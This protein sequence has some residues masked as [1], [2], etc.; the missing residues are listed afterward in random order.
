MTG[1]AYSPP[2][3]IESEDQL[4]HEISFPYQEVVETVSRTEGDFMI[5]G[6][7]GKI[8]PSLALMLKRAVEQAGTGKRVVAVDLFPEEGTSRQLSSRGIETVTCDLL[9]PKSVRSL[10]EIENIFFLAGRKF[11]STGRESLT[12]AMNTL[13]P[14]HVAAAFPGSRIVAFSTGCVYP[15]VS[16]ESA[17][18]KETDPPGPVGEYAQSCLGRERMFEHH[19]LTRNTPVCLIRLNYAIDLRYGVLLDLAKRVRSRQPVDLTMSHVNVIWQGDV[20]AR[21]IQ[22]L[23]LCVSPPRVLNVTGPE[24]ISVRWLAEQFGKHFHVRPAFEGEPAETMW[25]SN[26]SQSFQLFGSPHVSLET[27]INWVVHWVE[28]G[29]RDLQRPTHFEVHDGKF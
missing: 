2:Q 1:P 15:M 6:A 27:M 4:D 12:W 7:G 20:N 13:L 19:S 5:L 22:A 9:E 18:S 28:I 11:G 24:T 29:G 21:V 23:D 17:G 3:R 10:P 26:A 25:L 14:G 8:G 16:A